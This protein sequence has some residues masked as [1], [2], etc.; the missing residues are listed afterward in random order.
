V[1]RCLSKQGN[2]R[3]LRASPQYAIVALPV[4]ETRMISAT[5]QAALVEMETPA[6]GLVPLAG[7]ALAFLGREVAPRLADV[8]VAA[9][10]RRLTRPTT[11]TIAPLSMSSQSFGAQGRVERRQARYR[12][13]R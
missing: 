3:S 12:G 2:Y 1:H 4:A 9:L 13:G 8:L 7:A 10:E 5:N 6:R 11:T